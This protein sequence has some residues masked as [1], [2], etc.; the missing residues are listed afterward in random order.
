VEELTREVEAFKDGGVIA[1]RQALLDDANTTIKDLNAFEIRIE[2]VRPIEELKQAAKL[3]P[4][5]GSS[6]E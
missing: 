4:F 6:R 2:Q 3:T 5:K 1:R